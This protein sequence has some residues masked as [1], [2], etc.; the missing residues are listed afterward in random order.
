MSDHKVGFGH[1]W[2]VAGQ[3]SFIG[4]FFLLVLRRVISLASCCVCS[5]QFVLDNSLLGRR[6]RPSTPLEGKDEALAIFGS[7]LLLVLGFGTTVIR[8]L[9]SGFNHFRNTDLRNLGRLGYCGGGGRLLASFVETDLGFS[10]NGRLA[11][12]EEL[13]QFTAIINV[14]NKSMFLHILNKVL[15]LLVLGGGSFDLGAEPSSCASTLS[16]RS[17]HVFDEV[18]CQLLLFLDHIVGVYVLGLDSQTTGS[19]S[20][21]GLLI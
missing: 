11:S 14:L 8:S 6:K 12:V 2:L 5:S 19:S 18:C 10:S 17:N 9:S 7:R 16:A 20:N 1:D 3:A 15:R 4:A 21:G 13:L